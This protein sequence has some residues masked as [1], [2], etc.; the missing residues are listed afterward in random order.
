LEI[1]GSH[2]HRLQPLIDHLGLVTLVVTDLDAAEPIK[3]AGMPAGRGKSLVTNNNTL[4][5]WH[6]QKESVDE[7]LDLKTDQKVKK[8]DAFYSVRVAYQHPVQVCLNAGNKSEEAI[9]NTFEDA[10]VFENIPLFR[11]LNGPGLIGKFNKAINKV[12][13]CTE[14]EGEIFEHLKKGDKA[15]FALEM[16]NLENPDKLTIPLYI[17]EGLSWLQEQVKIR[18]QEISVSEKAETSKIIKKCK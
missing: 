11:E 8:G 17:S 15:E 3:G 1:G 18:E 10:L 14:L 4:K 16:L 5:K 7:L 9:S 6:P 2:A 13:S 12:K